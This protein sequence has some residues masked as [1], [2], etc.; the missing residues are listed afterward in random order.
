MWQAHGEATG[1]ILGPRLDALREEVGDVRTLPPEPSPEQLKDPVFARRYSAQKALFYYQSNRGVTNFPFFRASSQ[2]EARESGGKFVTVDARKTLWEADQARK[3]GDK[4]KAMQLYKSG[5]EKWRQVLLD[6]PDFYRPENGTRAEEDTYEFELDYLRLLVQDDPRVRQQARVI[7]TAAG[8]I[9]PFLPVPPWGAETATILAAANDQGKGVQAVIPFLS[10]PYPNPAEATGANA[11]GSP[12]WNPRAKQFITDSARQI[13]S[14]ES[15]FW[16]PEARDEIYWSIAES[17][18]P[19]FGTIPNETASKF[20][21]EPWIRASVKESVRV[22]QGV[23]R[24]PTTPQQP[25]PKQD[26]PRKKQ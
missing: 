19:F 14:A 5:L 13:Y 4:V 21:G 15:P 3:L 22:R 1:L 26:P 11:M 6:N 23:Q 18:S 17:F 9:I 8:S 10:P 25:V 2:A 16:R 12:L 20:R 7:G 24:K